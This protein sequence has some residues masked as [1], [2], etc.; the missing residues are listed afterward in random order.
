MR[1]KTAEPCSVPDRAHSH[2]LFCERTLAITPF[3]LGSDHFQLFFVARVPSSR[4]GQEHELKMA[5]ANIR[6]VRRRPHAERSGRFRLSPDIVVPLHNLESSSCQN[7]FKWSWDVRLSPSVGTRIG[8]REA[9]SLP[10]DWCAWENIPTRDSWKDV[11]A[12]E[13]ALRGGSCFPRI[14]GSHCF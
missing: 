11:G 2:R 6:W 8:S 13:R 3:V 14:P 12:P 7:S 10:V 9:V 4:R 5:T 1:C